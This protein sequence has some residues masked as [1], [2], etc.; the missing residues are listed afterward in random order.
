MYKIIIFRQSE[1]SACGKCILWILI[2][3][4]GIKSKVIKKMEEKDRAINS[5]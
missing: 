2:S 1:S 5:N 3:Q 4:I